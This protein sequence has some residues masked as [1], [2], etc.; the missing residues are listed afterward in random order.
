MVYL[1]SYMAYG[2][3]MPSQHFRSIAVP[4][5][6]NALM[7]GTMDSAM[8]STMDVEMQRLDAE[9]QALKDELES[10]KMTARTARIGLP[11]LGLASLGSYVSYAPLGDNL[12]V[13]SVREQYYNQQRKSLV[14][15]R[16]EAA[17]DRFF[18]GALSSLKTERLVVNQ[19]NKMGYTKDNTLFAS[20]T[21]PDEVNFK[22]GE[23]IDLFKTHYGE[24]FGLGGL[25]GVPFTGRA[26]FGAYSHHVSEGGKMFI[27]FAPHV[28]VEFDG[29]VGSLKRVNQQGVSSACGA[30]VGAFKQLMKQQTEPGIYGVK[31]GVSDY[32]DAQINFIKLKLA[33]RLDEVADAPDAYAFLTYQM[34]AIVREFFCDELLAAKPF[35]FATEVTVLGGI[36]IN[37]GVGGDR[38]MPLMFQSRKAEKGT[39]V[40]HFEEVFGPAPREAVEDVLAGSGIS[41]FDYDLDKRSADNELRYD[42]VIRR[43][44]A[45]RLVNGEGAEC[46]E[47][48]RIIETDEAAVA[49]EK[50]K[51]AGLK[52][53][54]SSEEVKKLEKIVKTTEAK[55][56]KQVTRLQKLQKEKLCPVTD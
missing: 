1:M 27:V 48:E 25:G 16:A 45:D 24:H 40:D 14:D 31:D 6:T 53:K 43:A 15:P 8:D 34:Y 54:G 36:M 30:A 38:F 29:V 32:F 7:Q 33:Q 17:C 5:S 9:V 2:L 11:L 47:L 49:Y 39:V 55:I 10:N 41:V 19:L 12:F 20:S 4:R 56:T 46:Y 13:D 44:K 23:I 26:G 18:P 22:P 3:V 37:R 21:C 52:K 51:L 42:K 50:G 28:G 35:D